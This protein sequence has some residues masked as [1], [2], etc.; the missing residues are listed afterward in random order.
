[1]L[2]DI[3]HSPNTF[4][5]TLTKYEYY[6]PCAPKDTQQCTTQPSTAT[7]KPSLHRSASD[8]IQSHFFHSSPPPPLSLSLSLSQAN[9]SA[10]AAVPVVLEVNIDRVLRKVAAKLLALLLLQGIPRN[11]LKCL[12]D[13]DG[14]LGR[15]LKIRD[16]A[17]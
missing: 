10:R 16:A 7:K 5:G 8:A 9:Q 14:L 15:G 6:S 12:L 4:P 2:C 13:V 11:D 17:L 1:M 3:N